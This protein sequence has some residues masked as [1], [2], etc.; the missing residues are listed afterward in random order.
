[1]SICVPA[2]QTATSSV[3][4]AVE[5]EA[6][7]TALLEDFLRLPDVTVETM[8]G[9]G[10]AHAGFRP[11]EGISVHWLDDGE[12]KTH[13]DRL[14]SAADRTLVVAPEFD[15]ILATRLRWVK[16]AK[17]RSLN[18]TA[19]AVVRTSDKLRL[20]DHLRDC[21]VPTP[22]TARWPA[23]PSA[24][25]AVCKP[26]CGAGSQATFLVRNPCELD[27]AMDGARAEGWSG[28]LIVQPF[29]PGE[30]VSVSFLIGPGRRLAMPASAQLLS[31]DGRF[32]YQGGRLP[33]DPQRNERAAQLAARAVDAVEGLAG[34]VGVDLVLGTTA[35][36]DAVIE[37]NPRVTTSY[38]GLRAL[39]N[40]NLTEALLAVAQGDEPRGWE[41]RT[42]PVRF[43]SDGGV[44]QRPRKCKTP[45]GGCLSAAYNAAYRRSG[46]APNTL[47]RVVLRA[48]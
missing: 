35:A 34:F 43:T 22:P 7:L 11:H 2:A 18:C 19:Q 1:M 28:D 21:G 15:D 32:R 40:F 38:V 16:A 27:R 25:P 46:S 20:A 14:T 24:F 48:L 42:D 44:A 29:L 17:G 26:R 33:L 37:I 23:R 45:L 13:F 9:R 10:V 30:A 41:W 6:M 5:G 47:D 8:L 31:T 36:E 39:A 3:S 4:L 12:E